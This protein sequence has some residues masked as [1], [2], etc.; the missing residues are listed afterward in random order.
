MIVLKNL[1][2]KKR[3]TK[4]SREFLSLG[5]TSYLSEL[6]GKNRQKKKIA[7][8]AIETKPTEVESK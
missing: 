1:I 3:R 8:P 7:R 2:V 4:Q 6:S 5:Q